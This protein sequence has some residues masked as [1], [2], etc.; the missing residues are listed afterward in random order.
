MIDPSQLPALWGNYASIAG[1]IFLAALVWLIPARLVF[2]EA[3]DGAR[4]RDIR[5]WAT[6]LIAAQIFLYLIFK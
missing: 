5:L 6:V 4:W 1:L 2:S 3:P